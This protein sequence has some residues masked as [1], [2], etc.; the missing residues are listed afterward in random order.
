MKKHLS[1]GKVCGLFLFLVATARCDAQVVEI[2]NPELKF[3]GTVVHAISSVPVGWK[4]KGDDRNIRMWNSPGKASVAVGGDV[5]IWQTVELP[6]LPTKLSEESEWRLILAADVIGKFTSHGADAEIWGSIRDGKKELARKKFSITDVAPIS[7]IA[8][9]QVSAS[10]FRSKGTRPENAFDGDRST[11]WRSKQ[12]ASKRIGSTHT[13][14]LD[15]GEEKTLR[16]IKYTPGLDNKSGDVRKFQIETSADGKKWRRV[17]QGEFKYSKRGE[18][19]SVSLRKP[20]KC[21]AFRLKCLSEIRG[22]R[23]AS[24]SELVPDLAEGFDGLTP[25]EIEPPPPFKRLFVPLDFRATQDL[26][27]V[28]IA[29]GVDSNRYVILNRVHLFWAPKIAT[30]KMR[31]K[32]N[33]HAGPDLLGAGS[34][35][36]QGLM[37]H[38]YPALPV[39]DIVR[40]S[41][42][43]KA[44]LKNTD[45][46]VGINDHFLPAGNVNPGFAWFESSHESLLG[47]AALQA[48]TTN[49]GK[50]RL[51]VLRDDKLVGINLHLKLPK[52]LGNEDFLVNHKSLE[53]L[54]QDLID[55]VV[56]TQLQD[57]SWKGN[58]IH[59]CLGGLALLST[60]DKKHA[61]RIKAAANWLMARNAEPGTGFY[62]HPAFSGIFLCEY[63]LATGDER[64][65]PVIDRLLRFMGTAFHT[66]KW[67]TE[68]F[69]HGPGGLPYGNKSLVAVMVHVLVFEALAERCGI[70]SNLYQRLSPYLE[71]AWSNPA[72]GGH[73]GL[74]Y[75]ASYKDQAEFWARSGLFGLMLKLRGIRPDMQQ[76]MAKI[77]FERYPWFRNSHAYGEPGGLLGFIGLSQINRAYFDETISRYRWWFALAWDQGR[78]L[79]FTVPHMGAPYME[80][81]QLINNGYSVVTNIHKKT[82]H[83]TGSTERN[84]LDVSQIP[85]PVS[86]P[87]ILLEPDGKVSMK[88]RIPGS[89]IHFTTNGS[90]PHRKSL[91]F[92]EPIT[93]R[94]GSVVKAI[95]F[96]GSNSS[97]VV[98]RRLGLNKSNWKVVSS[99][100]HKNPNT[101]IQHAAHL[102]DGDELVSWIPDAGEN[103]VGFPYEVVIDMGQSQKL[104]A[105]AVSF[106]SKSSAAAKVTVRGSASKKG[107]Y[108][109]IGTSDTDT[110]SSGINIGL[111]SKPPIR[112]LKVTFEKPFDNPK[113][114]LLIVGE[115]D[116][117]PSADKLKQVQKYFGC[118]FAGRVRAPPTI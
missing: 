26:K 43:A 108:Q 60:H 44:R 33:G 6:E 69:G 116:A 117:Y 111:N 105:M 24:C 23:V 114:R 97:R 40:N 101:A 21:R 52:E 83:I 96:S 45:L 94:P 70:Q 47:R 20:V 109:V 54:N 34:Y 112:Y 28:T 58:P 79:H 46:I 75:N 55:Q 10:S 3:E 12:K 22:A 98:A 99:N 38:R 19:Q 14:T 72:T 82:L 100:G 86:R 64:A 30:A 93:V 39:I 15:F 36:F 115:I 73:G 92:R 50:V 17:H 71:S 62:W 106:L 77:M 81:P 76:P 7:K 91:R 2:A 88:S 107:A 66:S 90:P 53:T 56:K 89:R 110:Y 85:V 37:I 27:R 68:T 11:L 87:M 113:N 5:S 9:V 103:T 51:N 31:G 49:R 63:Y 57:G 25:A 13:L 78:G 41:P 84:W 16:G 65:L 29:L 32:A 1:V 4:V 95:A 118:L 74:G 35:G 18:T 8:Q 42:A 48:I 104:D 102:I 67:G 59:T 61:R 80:G